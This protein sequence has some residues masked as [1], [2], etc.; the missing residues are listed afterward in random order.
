VFC[1]LFSIYTVKNTGAIINSKC[2]A[3]FLLN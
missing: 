1:A 2:F 3:F